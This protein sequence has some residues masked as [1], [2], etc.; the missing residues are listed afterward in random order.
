MLT[1]QQLKDALKSGKT[2]TQLAA[3]KGLTL[4][5]VQDKEK[6]L[7]KIKLDTLVQSSKITSA[8]ETNMLNRFSNPVTNKFNIKIGTR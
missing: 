7:L 4:T 2:L 8:Q 5:Q 1:P 3:D 6:E